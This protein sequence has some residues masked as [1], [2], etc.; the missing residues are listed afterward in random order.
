MTEPTLRDLTEADLEWLAQAERDLFG[1]GAWSAA[2]IREDYRWGSNRYRGI[3]INGEL[4]AY[5]IY[6]FEGDAFHLLNIAVLPAHRR[7][8]LGRLLFDEFLAEA[9]RLGAADV[10]L[11]VAVDN[12]AARAMYESYGFEQVRMRPRYYQPGD[13]DAVVMRKIMR[14]FTP[15]PPLPP[16]SAS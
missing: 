12:E 7:A 16:A 10:W 11:E 4:V 14:P 1:A 15:Q 2:L 6:G 13:I 3:E 9:Q 5:A 8:G